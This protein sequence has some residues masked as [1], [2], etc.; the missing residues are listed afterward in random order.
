MD[1]KI[2]FVLTV[3]GLLVAGGAYAQE[4]RAEAGHPG[5]FTE[6]GRQ[7]M[8]GRRGVGNGNPGMGW[9]NSSAASSQVTARREAAW[10]W[11]SS[12]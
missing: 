12:T 5:G 9:G 4:R 1:D 2:I 10:K 7:A 6:E 3:A 11:G 8:R